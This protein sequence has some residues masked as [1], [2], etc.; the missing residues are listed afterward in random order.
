MDSAYGS[1]SDSDEV[2]STSSSTGCYLRL[3]LNDID[4]HDNEIDELLAQQTQT[5]IEMKAPRPPAP[6][7]GRAGHHPS[8]ADAFHL[9][10]SAVA[11]LDHAREVGVLHKRIVASMDAQEV[12][13]MSS[14]VLPVFWAKC[15]SKGEFVRRA[16]HFDPHQMRA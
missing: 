8:D 11:L 4:V 9:A 14:T 5:C 13:A 2:S 16:M 3:A 7:F 6:A 1:L 10:R 12:H 15:G